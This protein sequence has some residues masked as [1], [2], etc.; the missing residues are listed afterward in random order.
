MNDNNLKRD[1]QDTYIDKGI[2]YVNYSVDDHREASTQ[3]P[4]SKPS[5]T[6]TIHQKPGLMSDAMTRAK[7]SGAANTN[8]WW[9]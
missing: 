2:D 8:R 1:G 5:Y 6:N 3:G 9:K 7:R 4:L